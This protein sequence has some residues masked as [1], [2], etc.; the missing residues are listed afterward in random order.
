MIVL[1][2]KELEK[3]IL[4]NLKERVARIKE[5]A[6]TNPTLAMISV[7]EDPASRTYVAKKEKVAKQLGINAVQLNLP[8]DITEDELLAEVKHYTSL[9]PTIVQLPLPSHISTSKVI[10]TID[11]RTDVDGFTSLNIGNML[12]DQICYIPATPKGILK[13]LNYFNIDTDGKNI[14]VVGRSNI[15]GRPLANLLSGKEYNA[16]VTLC[17]SHTQNLSQILKQMDVII[18]ATG[19]PN[20]VQVSDVKP[21]AV[22]IDV[23]VNRVPDD[24][25]RGWHLEGDFNPSGAKSTDIKYTPVPGGV[26]LLTVAMLMENTVEVYENSLKEL[27]LSPELV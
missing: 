1:K 10:D 2:C 21:D 15:V 6:D 25:E 22:I 13:I 27:V 3:S 5:I 11:P 9:A 18:V 7:G 17:H 4:E 19:H 24:T 20:T 16:T 14:A 26:G 12:L 8:A 23:G